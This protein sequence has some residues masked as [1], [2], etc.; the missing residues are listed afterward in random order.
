MKAGVFLISVHGT[1]DTV[2]PYPDNAEPIVTLWEQSGGRFKVFP[3]QGGD[4]HPHGLPDPAPL[5]ELLS[6]ETK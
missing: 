2:V 4:H 1:A 3:K 5:I 6:L